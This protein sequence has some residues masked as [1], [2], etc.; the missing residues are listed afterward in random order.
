MQD[1]KICSLAGMFS[2]NITTYACVTLLLISDFRLDARISRPG[3]E[4]GVARKHSFTKEV[5]LQGIIGNQI[6]KLAAQAHSLPSLFFL[7]QLQSI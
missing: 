7:H 1:D 3:G 5:K 6:D 2:N 4:I